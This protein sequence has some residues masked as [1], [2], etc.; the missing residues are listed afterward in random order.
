MTI[1]Q[2]LIDEIELL[3]EGFGAKASPGLRTAI[4]SVK[5]EIKQGEVFKQFGILVEQQKYH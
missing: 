2:E 1:S 4:E 5:R 3:L